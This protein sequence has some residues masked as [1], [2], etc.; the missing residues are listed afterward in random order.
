MGL[1]VGN[2]V[3]GSNSSNKENLDIRFNMLTVV[4]GRQT[5]ACPCAYVR[6]QPCLGAQPVMPI[7]VDCKWVC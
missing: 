3:A 7:E 6:A 5:E 1:R 2:V 4:A